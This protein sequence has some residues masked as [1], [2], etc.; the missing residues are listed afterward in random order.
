M[1][2]AKRVAIIEIAT[3]KVVGAG[4]L[5]GELPPNCFQPETPP[6][7]LLWVEHA[8]ATDG[9]TYKDGVFTPPPVEDGDG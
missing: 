5:G 2:A 8:R 1:S 3:G 4:M 9:W 6:E 7:G